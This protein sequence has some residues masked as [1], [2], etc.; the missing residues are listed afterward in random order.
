MFQQAAEESRR[1]R[2]QE[3]LAAQ[4]RTRL[5]QIRFRCEVLRLVL[6]QGWRW[7]QVLERPSKAQAAALKDF[8]AMIGVWSSHL[9]LVTPDE[10]GE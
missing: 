1:Q 9:L 3:L 4:R 6:E 2:Q 8:E 7:S 5:S 10:L